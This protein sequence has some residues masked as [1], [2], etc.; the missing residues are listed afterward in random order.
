LDCNT[1]SGIFFK[2]YQIVIN[3]QM[4][5][6]I[7]NSEM[8]LPVLDCPALLP[9]I[10]SACPACP[11]LPCLVVCCV[12]VAATSRASAAP[13]LALPARCVCSLLRLNKKPASEGVI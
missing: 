8:P 7:S 13:C 4:F 3:E 6:F 11:A 5:V 12:L 10:A 1:I 9:A 2:S